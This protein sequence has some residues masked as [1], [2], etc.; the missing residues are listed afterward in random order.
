MNKTVYEYAMCNLRERQIAR[1]PLKT[2][3]RLTSAFGHPVTERRSYILHFFG[4]R[5][6][7]ND[8]ADW[9][10]RLYHVHP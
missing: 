10:L 2:A 3:V 5:Q 7:T 8:N 1:L 6:V 9:N 4:T